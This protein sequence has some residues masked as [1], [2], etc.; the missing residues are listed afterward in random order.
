MNSEIK[1]MMPESIWVLQRP[2]IIIIIF[3]DFPTL[4]LMKYDMIVN[5]EFILTFY[6]VTTKC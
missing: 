3:T 5:Y 2:D 4:I 6:Y 1:Y